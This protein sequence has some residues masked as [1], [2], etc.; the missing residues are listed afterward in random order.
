MLSGFSKHPFTSSIVSKAQDAIYNPFPPQPVFNNKLV[1]FENAS[2]IA[3]IISLRW[4]W[5]GR[6]GRKQEAYIANDRASHSYN[7]SAQSVMSTCMVRP[8]IPNVYICYGMRTC[9]IMVTNNA[10]TN[11]VFNKEQPCLY[12]VLK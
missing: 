12:L 1:C 3:V 4:A 6:I 10:G 2:C 7:G 8:A 11:S 5:N 9:L